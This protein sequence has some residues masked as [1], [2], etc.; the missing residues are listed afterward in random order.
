M[1]H[2]VKSG[3]YVQAKIVLLVEVFSKGLQIGP[4]SMTHYGRKVH[5]VYKL[6]LDLWFQYMYEFR[7]HMVNQ[8]TIC[9]LM[10]W[11][12]IRWCG[13]SSNGGLID[14]GAYLELLCLCFFKVFRTTLSHLNHEVH[15]YKSLKHGNACTH[16]CAHTHTHY[17]QNRG[18]TPKWSSRFLSTCVFTIHINYANIAGD[19]MV[20]EEA[21]GTPPKLGI[22]KQIY[23]KHSTHYKRM[24]IFLT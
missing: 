9:F 5:I 10:G 15:L 21:T 4:F 1:G 2:N 6:E 11:Q 12:N 22:P 20:E 16:L 18:E 3:H 8:M 23:V 19:N 7:Q 17:G 14:S 13:P 24:W